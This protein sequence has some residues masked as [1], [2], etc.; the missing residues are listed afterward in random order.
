[1]KLKENIEYKIGVRPDTNSIIEVYQSSGIS[2]PIDDLERIEQMYKN[3]NLI[4]SAWSKNELVGISR[5]LTDFNYCCYLSDLAV[6]KGFQNLGIGKEL[7]RITKIEIGER[8]ML[9]L[10]SA[11]NAMSYYPKIGFETVENGFILR[12]IT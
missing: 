7:L 1:M 3:S 4:I 10:L 6:K 11:S 8:V 2:R 5:A 12:R 9:L